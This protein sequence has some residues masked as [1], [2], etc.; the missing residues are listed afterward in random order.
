MHMEELRSYFHYLRVEKGLAANTVAGYKNDLERYAEYLREAGF[1]KLSDVK[2]ADISVYIQSLG[3]K[4]LRASSIARA[5]SSIRGLH[6]FVFEEEHGSANPTIL[7]EGPKRE[8]RLPETLTVDEIDRILNHIE[9]DD[10]GLWIRNR[11]LLEFLYAT[12]VR[13]SELT[14]L[15]RS[16]ILIQEGVVRIFGKGSKERIVPVGST[17]M[18]WLQKYFVEIRPGL[19]RYRLGKD[20]VFLN[21]RGA[22]L[23][24]M[25]VW[26]ILRAAVRSAGIDKR[27]YPHILRHSFAT[28]MLERGADLRSVQELLGHAD[29]STTQIYTHVDTSYLRRIHARYHPRN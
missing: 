22:P 2:E 15:T 9:R 19:A 1:R 12:G 13:V 10:K 7:I 21:R 4:G 20:I 28:H 18:E 6:K 25:A 8:K 26:N 14:G 16:Q 24:R 11:A 27:I 3:K 29:I 23:S 17:A 5:L